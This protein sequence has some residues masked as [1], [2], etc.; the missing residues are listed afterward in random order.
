MT[1]LLQISVVILAFGFSILSIVAAPLDPNTTFRVVNVSVSDTSGLNVRD[2]PVEASNLG[3]AKVVGHLSWQA[4]GI[5]TSGMVVRFPN[6]A[7]WRHIRFGDIIG[8]VNGKF[9]E[10]EP[11]TRTGEQLPEKLFC[12]GTEPFWGLRVSKTSST[13]DGAGLKNDKWV[14][15]E[16]LDFLA[17]NQIAGRPTKTWSVTLKQKS[18]S[19][20]IT[21]LISRTGEYCSDGMSDRDY[22]YQAIVLPGNVPVP[23]QGCCQRDIG[24]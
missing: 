24:R 21:T 17:S 20:Y 1:K 5:I 7:L 19:Q 18:A 15:D 23:M 4:S 22:P 12:G 16:K 11:F 9:L 13:Y 14:E 2:F 10:A 8:W 3:N 6:G